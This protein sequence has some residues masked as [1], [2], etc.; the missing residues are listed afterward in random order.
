M[1]A[2]DRKAVALER[3][4]AFAKRICTLAMN[5]PPHLSI[6]L[7][8]IIR[9]LL[10]KFPKVQQLLGSEYTYAAGTYNAIID[11]PDHCGP[12]AT[13]LWDINLLQAHWHP[14]VA[15]HS[16][17]VISSDPASFDVKQ[18]QT[19]YLFHAY[20]ASGGG[21]NPPIQAPRKHRFEKKQNK[22]E[23]F[24]RPQKQD[25]TFTAALE[26]QILVSQPAPTIN[27]AKYFKALRRF[28]AQKKLFRLKRILGKYEVYKSKNMKRK[29]QTK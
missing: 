20:D 1:I 3:V 21:F 6:A 26:S 22:K 7:L 16:Q 12:F 19:E 29:L 2:S 27:L 14:V 28:D 17:Q 23:Q 13:S 11:Q 18:G 4:A 25:T 24:I 15:K 5:S 8:H 9:I 10:A